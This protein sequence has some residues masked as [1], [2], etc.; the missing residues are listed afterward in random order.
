MSDHD[1]KARQRL[2]KK[3]TK[4]T[5]NKVANYVTSLNKQLKFSQSDFIPISFIS[6]KHENTYFTNPTLM[7]NQLITR[8]SLQEWLKSGRERISTSSLLLGDG[9]SIVPNRPSK[10]A[11]GQCILQTNTE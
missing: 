10:M 4:Q 5:L 7:R 8:K 3:F 11:I 6:M 2:T 9:A 1:Q